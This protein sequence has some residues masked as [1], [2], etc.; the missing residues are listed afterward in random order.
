MICTILL[1]IVL[2]IQI[3]HGI[4]LDAST[5]QLIQNQ[6][7]NATNSSNESNF[8]LCIICYENWVARKYT[9]INEN[10]WKQ[11]IRNRT[12][13]LFPECHGSELC[14][15]CIKLC[16]QC[17]LCRRP[18]NIYLRI[19]RKI[20]SCLINVIQSIVWCLAVSLAYFVLLI[21]SALSRRVLYWR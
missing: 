9:R 2:N 13:I 6:Q 11:L 10:R 12:N 7:S 21:L 20:K 14:K 5:R 16:D 18:K 3:I 15:R 1:I 19:N 4:S 17:P 8:N